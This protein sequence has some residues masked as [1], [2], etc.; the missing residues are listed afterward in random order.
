MSFAG[1]SFLLQP[2][3]SKVSLDWFK[4]SRVVRKFGLV[5]SDR[6]AWDILL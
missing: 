5:M 3:Y 6:F 2:P 1:T 4:N